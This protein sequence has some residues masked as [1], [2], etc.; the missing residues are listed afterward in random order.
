MHL[1]NLERKKQELKAKLAS[2]KEARRQDRE[3]RRA[4]GEI[5]ESSSDE[6]EDDREDDEDSE[7]EQFEEGGEED[8][9][10]DP[11]APLSESRNVTAYYWNESGEY[12]AVAQTRAPLVGRVPGVWCNDK[13]GP[14]KSLYRKGKHI[15]HFNFEQELKRKGKILAKKRQKVIRRLDKAMKLG[16]LCNPEVITELISKAREL[17]GSLALAAAANAEKFLE[18]WEHRTMCATNIQRVFRATVCRRVYSLLKRKL[19]HDARNAMRADHTRAR[20]ARDRVKKWKAIAAR[21][22]R[23]RLKSLF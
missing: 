6:E 10:A 2:E 4:E 16:D 12:L 3:R 8:N 23:R 5:V 21:N 11:E 19:A 18:Q 22:A 15:K 9:A 14:W 17:E 20:L 7:E 1:S 13:A